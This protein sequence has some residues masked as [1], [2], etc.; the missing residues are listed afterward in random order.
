MVT[1]AV[2]T[3]RK[4]YRKR[5]D[6]DSKMRWRFGRTTLPAGQTPDG[7]LHS[8]G[9]GDAVADLRSGSSLPPVNGGGYAGFMLGA[10]PA[11]RTTEESIDDMHIF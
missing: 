7:D 2:Q 5:E 11:H 4:A 3:K 8:E 10:P 6:S 9:S 1:F